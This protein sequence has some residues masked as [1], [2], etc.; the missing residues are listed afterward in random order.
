MGRNGLGKVEAV[1]GEDGQEE[2]HQGAQGDQDQC[3]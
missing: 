3:Q 1:R 2:G